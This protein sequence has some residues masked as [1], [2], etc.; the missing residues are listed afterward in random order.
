[1]FERLP[2]PFGLVRFGVAP[3]HPEVKN[4]VND[5]TSVAETPDFRFF[6]NVEVGS[7]VSLKALEEAYDA[8]VM[9]TG[10]EGERMLRI[11]GEEMKGV[12]GAPA[13]VKWYNGHPDFVSLDTQEPGESAVVLGQ[14]N[15]A[16]DIGRIL[17]RGQKELQ[18][19]DINPKALAQI[20]EWQ[21]RGLRTVH[22]VGRRGFVQA[23]FTNAELREL[24]TFSDEALC[25]VDP[26]ELARCRNPA[27]EEELG[28]SRMKKRS[29]EILDKMANNFSQIHTTSKRILQLRFLSSPS[30]ILPGADGLR[31]ASIRLDRTELKGEPGKQV[32]AKAEPPVSQD[33]PAGLI[34]RSI[35]FDLTPIPGLPLNDHRRVPHTKGR[36]QRPAE[37]EHDRRLYV[38]GW[39]KRGPQGIIASN[40]AD[41]QETAKQILADLSR[42]GPSPR[43][44]TAAVESA[45]G[46]S[47]ARTVNFAD[48]RR[49][50]AEE[51]RRGAAS[52]CSAEKL[53]DVSEMLRL[54]DA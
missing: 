24:L 8:V 37:E 33:L 51:F 15:V 19:T 28:K 3:D 45:L 35:G 14:G 27:S 21:R 1:M 41:A 2:V 36:V 32:A 23:A 44:G 42:E 9:C 11:P 50:E 47:G 40:I 46:A 26:E 18:A 20:G 53:T 48:W 13:F 39:V 54:L 10:A 12:V 25:V 16:L 30:A 4:V 22:I 31:A 38:S 34:V 7:N 49:I 5:F 6:G 29:V 52:G 17:V 43:S